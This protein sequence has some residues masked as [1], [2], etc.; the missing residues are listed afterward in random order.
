[1]FDSKKMNKRQQR[2]RQWHCGVITGYIH[3][4]RTWK[5]C[6]SY[7]TLTL[8]SEIRLLA[9]HPAGGRIFPRRGNSFR[10]CERVSTASFTRCSVG[11]SQCVRF[12]FASAAD[13]DDPSTWTERIE[14]NRPRGSLVT[15]TNCLYRTPS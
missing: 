15:R 10:V 3:V 12:V 13:D 14:T 2:R 9:G 1:M 8:A 4:K 5:S 7:R 6:V 11:R